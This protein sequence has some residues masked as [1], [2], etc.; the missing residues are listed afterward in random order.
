LVN[1]LA[2]KGLHYRVRDDNKGT[3]SWYE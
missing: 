1:F 2:G 3:L